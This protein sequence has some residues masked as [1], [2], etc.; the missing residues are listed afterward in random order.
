MLS[1]S[2]KPTTLHPLSQPGVSNLQPTDQI[3]PLPV[4]IKFYWHIA[5]P[6]AC[7]CK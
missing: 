1:P 3:Q 5:R 4:L 6:S 2:M 7:S